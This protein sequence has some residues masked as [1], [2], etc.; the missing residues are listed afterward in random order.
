MTATIIELDQEG[1]AKAVTTD[2]LVG[3]LL[4]LDAFGM[5]G[6]GKRITEAAKGSLGPLAARLLQLLRAET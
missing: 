1:A 4:T 2:A 3:S 6:R 5:G